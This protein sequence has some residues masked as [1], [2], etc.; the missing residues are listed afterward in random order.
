MSILQFL[1]ILPSLPTVLP[2]YTF[3][4]CLLL[5]FPATQTHRNLLSC[6]LFV[7]SSHL[8]HILSLSVV[9]LF[10]LLAL[11]FRSHL[12]F[13]ILSL[14][15]NTTIFQLWFPCKHISCFNDCK[16]TN[17]TKQKDTHSSLIHYLLF[18]IN[19]FCKFHIFNFLFINI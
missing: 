18:F 12:Q 7:K 19:I 4:R 2:L 6:G 3:V 10:Q 8:K 15:V 1:Q 16:V 13:M 11:L 14:E 9:V 17:D 5:S